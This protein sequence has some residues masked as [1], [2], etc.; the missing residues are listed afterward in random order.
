MCRRPLWKRFWYVLLQFICRL[1]ALIFFRI[2]CTGKENFPKNGG[3]LVLSNHQSYLDPLLIGVVCDRRLNFLARDDLF[4]AAPFRWLIQS[5]DA[6]PVARHGKGFGG[7]KATLQRLERGEMVLLFPEGTRTRDGELAPLAPGFGLVA[8]KSRVPLIPVAIHGAF[9][10]WPRMKILPRAA[11]IRIH[12]GRP[13]E[14]SSYAGLNNDQLVNEI[15]IRLREAMEIAAEI[16]GSA[17]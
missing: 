12:V 2:R 6:I 13:L 3:A 8:R 17:N 11:P 7:L 5:L 1:T 4:R 16:A 9:D 10:A 14:P 15:A